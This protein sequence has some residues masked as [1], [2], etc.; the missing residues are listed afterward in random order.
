M[1]PQVIIVG[2]DKGGV[3]KTT[4]C[5]ALMDYYLDNHKDGSVRAFDTDQS[6][7]APNGVL[8]R[9]YPNK[10]ELVDLTKSDDQMRVFD[11]LRE[12]PITI[13][14]IR[15][16][17]LSPMLETLTNIGFMEKSRRDEIGISV[18]HVLGGSVASLGEIQKISE[19]LVHAKHY[20]VKNHINDNSFFKWNPELQRL[21]TG[22]VIDIPKMDEL[23]SESVDAASQSFTDYAAADKSAVLCGYVRYWLSLVFPE[24]DK[25]GLNTL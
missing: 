21:I 16:T 7:T 23:A 15:A 24:F 8:H 2:A 10:S 20:L 25:V 13:I 6:D 1:K 5:R 14:D 22:G 18:L 11:T 3:G 17:L 9:F 12:T 19:R 4:V